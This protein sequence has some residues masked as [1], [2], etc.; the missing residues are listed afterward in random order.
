M[1]GLYAITPEGLMGSRLLK[2]VEEALEGGCRI[3]QYRNKTSDAARRR[4]DA[5]A[6]ARLCRIH[7]A[8][9][10]VNDDAELAAAVG[11][12]GVHLGRDDDSLT[13]A[14]AMLGSDAIIGISCYDDWKRAM[15]AMQQGAGYVAF[16]TFYPSPTKP[17]AARADLQLLEQARR[18]LALPVVAIGGITPENAQPLIDAGADMVAVIQGLFGRSDIRAAAHR[19]S[20][21]FEESRGRS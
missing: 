10:I 18:E 15:A 16:G 6:L 1:R 12:D 5:E 21:L 11:A 19:L 9:F 2:A 7:G 4:Q 8:R 3:L 20:A 14:R 13:K 17:D